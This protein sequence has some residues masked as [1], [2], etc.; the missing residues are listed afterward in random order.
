MAQ[1]SEIKLLKRFDQDVEITGNLTLGGNA[2]GINTDNFY[3]DGITKSGNTLTFSVNGATN[4]TYTFGSNAFTSYTNHTGLYLSLSGGIIN[5]SGNYPLQSI[6]SQRYIYQARNSSNTINANYGWWWFMNTDFTMGFHADGLGD[7]MSL[8]K[9]GNLTVTG[10]FTSNISSGSIISTGASADAFGYNSNYGHYIWGNGGTYIY[11]NG[12]FY[13]G[14]GSWYT[15]VHSGNIGSYSVN[16]A[17]SSAYASNADTLDNLNSTQFLRSDQDDEMNGWLKTYS[18]TGSGDNIRHSLSNYDDTPQAA[19]VGGQLVLG[20][21]YTDSGSYTE[22]AILKMYKENGTSGHYGS[23]LK[24]QVRNNGNNLSTKMVLNP[25]GYLSV[26]H[27]NPYM[28]LHVVGDMGVNSGSLFIGDTSGGNSGIQIYKSGSDLRFYRNEGSFGGGY[29]AQEVNL[30]LYSGSSYAVNISGNG[31]TYF[32]G[33]RVGIGTST[34]NGRFELKGNGNQWAESPAIRLWDST[35][36]KGWYL[37][38]AYNDT[39]GDFYIRTLPSETGNPA[40]GQQEFTIKHATG[41]IGIGT[42]NPIDKLNIAGGVTSTGLSTPSNMSVGSIQM[43]YDGTNGIIRTWNSS[44]LIFSIYNYYRFDVSGSPAM[45]ISTG[46]NVGIGTSS[47]SYKLEVSGDSMITASGDSIALMLNTSSNTQANR[48]RF[49]NGN[50]DYWSF[51][52]RGINEGSDFKFYRYNN[53]WDPVMTLDWGD[54]RVGIQTEAPGATLDINGTA[55]V[56][57]YNSLTL[58]GVELKG[59]SSN[60]LWFI[61]NNSGEAQFIISTSWDWDKQVEFRYNPNTVGTPDGVLSIGQLQKNAAT[62]T[63]GTTN[64]FT[65]GTLAAYITSGQ[66]FYFQQDLRN[67]NYAVGSD[68]LNIRGRSG[69]FIRM[70]AD[71]GGIGL[72][73]KNWS[74]TVHFSNFSNRFELYHNNTFPINIGNSSYKSRVYTHGYIEFLGGTRFIDV[75]GT[76]N[77]YWGVYGWDTQLQFTKRG[78][79]DDSYQ[80]TAMFIEYNGNYVQS[81]QSFR[82]PIF[83]D[84]NNTSYYVDADATSRL[85]N[86]ELRANAN[87]DIFD[88]TNAAYIHCDARP[89]SDFSAAYKYTVKTGGGYGYYREYWWDGNSYQSIRQESDAFRFSCDVI[90]YDTSD[91]RLKKNITPIDKAVDKV[92]KLGGYEF[93]WDE[94]KQR[95]HKGRDIGVIAQEVEEIYPQAVETRDNGYKAVDYTKLVPV[96]IQAIKE[97]QKQIDKLKKLIN[98]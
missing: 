34:P 5:S 69:Q 11:G 25:S 32:N 59:Y 19:G 70:L 92:L 78:I 33:G 23:G 18:T 91:K 24:F 4:Q 55:R 60:N 26:G 68:T 41:N 64:F 39:P 6:S 20:Y 28:H 45:T 74:H 98:P 66:H 43:G 90:A 85:K 65:N 37:G 89:E 46:R 2:I 80:G 61:S 51:D 29:T 40:S 62:W 35:N 54:G 75:N 82:S 38:S 58:N 3:L 88:N 44:P 10:K 17:N 76:V 21:K 16:Y 12:T 7:K 72:V 93:D 73:D 57:D 84:S 15:L 77:S 31:N 8:T 36:A 52:A 94:D 48:L 50:T 79:S 86:L 56:R 95:H 9:E 81:D 27:T 14:S 30:Q 87:F 53:G 22:G 83:Y 1:S 97:Q 49:R 42:V 63:H 96:L 67:N 71:D 13:N 47:P